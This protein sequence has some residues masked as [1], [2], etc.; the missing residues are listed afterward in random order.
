MTGNEDLAGAP[1]V[2][3]AEEDLTVR[4]ARE[5]LER[6]KAEGVSLVHRRGYGARGRHLSQSWLSP[7]PSPACASVSSGSVVG[8]GMQTTLIIVPWA[9]KW[10]ECWRAATLP[11]ERADL[12]ESRHGRRESG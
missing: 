9:P 5:L 12:P 7:S 2:Q 1:A 3:Q 10:K 4:V 11:D 6:A 8:I